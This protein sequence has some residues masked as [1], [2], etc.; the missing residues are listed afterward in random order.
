MQKV[1]QLLDITKR[2][3]NQGLI[4]RNFSS[5][6]AHWILQTHI[7]QSPMEDEIIWSAKVTGKYSVKSGY[8]FLINNSEE[9]TITTYISKFWKILWIINTLQKSKVFIWRLCNNALATQTNIN[10][11][12]IALYPVCV[13]CKK[14]NKI[15]THIFR[16]C[17]WARRLWLTCPL[18]INTAAGSLVPIQEWV[19]GWIRVLTEKD[20]AQF[21]STNL[22][23]AGLWAMWKY[24]N[25]VILRNEEP[26]PTSLMETMKRR[27][28]KVDG[29]VQHR[30]HKGARKQQEEE[31]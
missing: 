10:R 16:D 23:F 20:D 28:T 29:V 22:I 3:W 11:R 17:E 24:R 5:I 8:A 4:C 26:N 19:K 7:P 31:E 25:E 13:L 21:S 1:D 14:E 30:I 6:D 15:S 18:G 9:H 2:N 27:T 12:G